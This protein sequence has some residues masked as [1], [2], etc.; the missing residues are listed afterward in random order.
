M[1]TIPE[2]IYE[3]MPTDI[4]AMFE[5]L[6]NDGSPEVVR[7]F[8]ETGPS[9]SGVRDPNG[10]MGYH[11]GAAGLPG[12]VSGHNDNGGSAARFFYTAKASKADRGGAHN[13]HPT[14]KPLD[15]MRYLCRLI[16]PPGGIVLDPYAGSGTTLVA[17]REEGFKYI[18][19]EMDAESVATAERRL[20]EKPLNLFNQDFIE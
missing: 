14:V 7:L 5:K 12:V 3:K 9:K 6:P 16:T 18:G 13:K 4:K 17:A 10:T 2:S 19:A 8:P 15:L 11:G 1:I 20:R